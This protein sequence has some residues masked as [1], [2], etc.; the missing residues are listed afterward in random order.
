MTYSTLFVPDTLRGFPSVVY[1]DESAIGK[2]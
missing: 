2:F 1:N